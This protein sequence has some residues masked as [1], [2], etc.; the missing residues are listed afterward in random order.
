MSEKNWEKYNPTWLVE[1]AQLLLPNEAWL[2][3][4]LAECTQYYQD[5]PSYLYFIDRD[6][7]PNRNSEW[8]FERNIILR[9]PTRGEVVLDIL[10]NKKVGGVEL[11]NLV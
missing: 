1:L 2:A 8:A 3:E 9:H 5:G 6:A 11:L 10:K 7:A 4:A